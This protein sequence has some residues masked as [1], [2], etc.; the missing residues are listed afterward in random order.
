MVS[1]IIIN[2]NTFKLTCECIQSIYTNITVNFEIILI[3][4]ASTESH[5]DL[6]LEEFPTINLLKSNVNL[7]FSKGNN[8]GIKH[9]KGEYI[10]LL[11]SDTIFIENCITPCLSVLESLPNVGIISP[12][13]LNQD[14]TFQRNARKFKNIKRELFD[15]FKPFIKIL[16]YKLYSRYCLNNYFNG[17]YDTY[18]DWIYGAFFMFRRKDLDKYGEKLDERFFMYGEDQLWS[19]QF[20]QSLKLRTY[21]L[22]QTSLIHLVGKSGFETDKLSKYFM[23]NGRETEIYKIRNNSNI[24]KNAFIF[25]LILNLK[26]LLLFS[27][28]YFNFGI[29][30]RKTFHL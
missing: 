22:S 5:P 30:Y 20:E 29:K 26:T 14:L 28:E 11:N 10:I 7:G 18:C 25:Q 2:Y 21:F 9:A 24:V 16:P 23:L 4:N 13:L 19:W 3:D 12:K 8:L 15:L 17:D 6:F 27:L 1:I